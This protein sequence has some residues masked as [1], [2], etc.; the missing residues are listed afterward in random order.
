MFQQKTNSPWHFLISWTEVG[1]YNYYFSINY[2]VI[3]NFWHDV[4]LLLPVV[5]KCNENFIFLCG[6][7][8]GRAVDFFSV[9]FIHLTQ[10]FIKLWGGRG[11]LRVLAFTAVNRL[12]GNLGK[13]DQC[14]VGKWPYL[15]VYWKNYFF[16]AEK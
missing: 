11:S 3:W 1:H 4:C 14:T 6:V 13:L 7:E 8:F 15:S 12:L 10:L 2:S 9:F 5:W 16:I